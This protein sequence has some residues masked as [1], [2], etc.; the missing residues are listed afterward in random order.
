MDVLV[1]TGVLLRLVIRTDPAHAEARDAIRVLK[2]RG[3]RLV[4][5]TQNAAEFWNVSTRPSSAR[6]G[7]GLSVEE[8]AKRFRLIERLIEIRSD[9]DAIFQEWKRLLVTHSVLGVQ[10]YD[11]RIAAAMNVYGVTHLLT[12]NSG[13]FK[14]YPGIV[15]THPKD[16]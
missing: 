6:G 9:T 5:L 10:V 12:F 3:D 7:Y 16:V 4:A 1:D 11:A 13:D 15:A 14:R 8:T 2:S